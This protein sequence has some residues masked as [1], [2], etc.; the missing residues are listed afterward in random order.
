[1]IP[2]GKSGIPS[3][4]RV[5]QGVD[6]RAG[7]S[8]IPQSRPCRC[9]TYSIR[10][11][12]SSPLARYSESEYLAHALSSTRP[13]LVWLVAWRSS[14]LRMTKLSTSIALTLNSLKRA[15]D[16]MRNIEASQI[17]RSISASGIIWM[18]SC[19]PAPTSHSFQRSKHPLSV[20]GLRRI[21]PQSNS[22]KCASARVSQQ[23][24][25]LME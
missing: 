24:R 13:S 12:L 23:R 11:S 2:P 1:M 19:L 9:L 21:T 15:R 17:L 8:L 14:N 22:R 3:K 4:R 6:S 18:Q 5:I 10:W 20:C 16:R 7:S 25:K